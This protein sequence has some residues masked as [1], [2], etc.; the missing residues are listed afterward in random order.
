VTGV[1]SDPENESQR[2]IRET[3]HEVT[4]HEG[5]SGAPSSRFIFWGIGPVAANHKSG[6]V[7]LN[8]RDMRFVTAKDAHVALPLRLGK[9]AQVLRD[10]ELAP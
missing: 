9:L 3:F 6:T 4:G 7:G 5:A 2:E 10:L 8:G 1:F